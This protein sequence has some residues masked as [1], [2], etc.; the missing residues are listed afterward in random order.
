MR[1]RKRQVM[2]AV[3]GWRAR[4]LGPGVLG[5]LWQSVDELGWLPEEPVRVVVQVG[6]DNRSAVVYE[7][8]HAL[9]DFL[10]VR[11][12][13]AVEVLDPVMDRDSWGNLSVLDIPREDVLRLEAV[14]TCGPLAVPR[15]WFSRHF[16]VT[17]TGV[18]PSPRAR[19][20]ALLGAQAELLRRLGNEEPTEVVVYEAH[21]L[22]AS[23]LSVICGHAGTSEF[24][25]AI[26]QSDVAVEQAVAQAAGIKPGTLPWLRTLARHEVLDA[27]PELLGSLPSLREYAASG[28][29]T[30]VHGVGLRIAAR[31]SAAGHDARMFR[32]AV[33]KIPAVVRRLIRGQ[34]A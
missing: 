5:A 30:A 22:A 4:S 31:V 23:D 13:S 16:L 14:A 9:A 11:R 19:I 21:R 7:T 8:V 32:Q 24:W 20:S 15:F 18:G 29:W 27:V 1:E 28:W 3:L 34:A 2:P 26:G 6:H 25:W 33:R 17:V 10:M 12:G